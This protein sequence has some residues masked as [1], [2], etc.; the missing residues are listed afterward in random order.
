MAALKSFMIS[1]L[2][3]YDGTDPEYNDKRSIDLV[4]TNVELDGT[5]I[6]ADVTEV[7]H[8][9]GGDEPGVESRTYS[10]MMIAGE[11]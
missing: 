4:F 7:Y 6:T 3:V 1:G 11:Y 5:T 2:C 8:W 10:G 9:I